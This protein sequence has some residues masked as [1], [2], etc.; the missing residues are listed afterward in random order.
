LP[1]IGVLLYGL[2]GILV[3]LHRACCHRAVAVLFAAVT[4]VLSIVL[5]T[6]PLPTFVATAVV[7]VGL[8]PTHAWL[9]R[10][11]GRLL[12]GPASDPLTAVSRLGLVVSRA[13][14]GVTSPRFS[15]R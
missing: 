12:D 13:G 4:T 3:V 6:G 14:E 8:A 2:L 5:P 10:F 9:R 7:A 15:P 1:S 11:V